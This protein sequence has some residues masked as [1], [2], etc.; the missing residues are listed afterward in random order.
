MTPRPGLAAALGLARSLLM[1]YAIPGRARGWRR[2]YSH[3]VSAGDLCFDLGAHV[4]N[5]SAAL[6]ALGARVVALEPQPL[7]A[8]A[9]RRLHG[10]NPRLT[11]L[12]LAAGRTA[13]RAELLVSR[14]APTVSTLSALWAEQ[15]AA[16]PGFANIAWDQRLEVRLTTLDALIAEYGLPALCKIDVEGYE[17]DVLQGLSQPI[18]LIS[19]EYI[20]AVMP[21]AL[22]CLERLAALGN[23]QFNL[24]RSEAPQLALPAWVSA[25][26]LA[27]RLRQIPAHG[28]A[29]EVYA[30]LEAANR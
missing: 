10:R 25:E 5:R 17:L 3:F 15:V 30:L 26:E 28:R 2:F 11:L 14:R 19:F 21:A 27:A 1:Y 29:G 20:P 23:Y 16:T 13:G 7:P 24:M 8:A 6:L 22:A 9:L 12:P 4:G 18:A